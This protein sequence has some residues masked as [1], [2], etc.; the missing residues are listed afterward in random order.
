MLAVGELVG[1]GFLTV[2]ALVKLD[3][4]TLF[5]SK[6]ST[7]NVLGKASGAGKGVLGG[8]SADVGLAFWHRFRCKFGSG[9][10][11]EFL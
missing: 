6:T 11:E 10:V 5:L 1:E 3:F 8:P 4:F 7:D 2:F 9:T